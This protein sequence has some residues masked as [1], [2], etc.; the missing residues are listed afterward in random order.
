MPAGKHYVDSHKP[1]IPSP[2]K[3]SASLAASGWAPASLSWPACH[4]FYPSLPLFWLPSLPLSRPACEA[5]LCKVSL[6]ELEHIVWDP[7]ISCMLSHALEQGLHSLL[8][9]LFA[10]SGTSSTKS[11][12]FVCVPPCGRCLYLSPLLLCELLQAL[13]VRSLLRRLICQSGLSSCITGGRCPRRLQSGLIDTAI[14]SR[15]NRTPKV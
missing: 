8:L 7:D 13:A 15:V 4:P 1:I 9:P 3:Y 14:P 5:L 6:H 12:I 11:T 2:C 10:S